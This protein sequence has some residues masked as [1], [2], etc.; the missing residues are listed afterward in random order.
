MVKTPLDTPVVYADNTEQDKNTP[1]RVLGFQLISCNIH[2][3]STLEQLGSNRLNVVQYASSF[4]LPLF[5]ICCLG[6]YVPVMNVGAF[7][8]WSHYRIANA[9]IIEFVWEIGRLLHN[10]SY[11]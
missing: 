2:G 3:R 7:Y 1:F 5:S 10:S 11:Q 4:G 9:T 6:G 8:W